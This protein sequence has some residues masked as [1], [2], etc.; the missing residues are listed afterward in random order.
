ME[1]NIKL[2]LQGMSLLL[3]FWI[4]ITTVRLQFDNKL[5]NAIIKKDYKQAA[6][7]A[8]EIMFLKSR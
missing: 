7:R 6:E 1:R 4:L 8:K 2:S 3:A 5:N